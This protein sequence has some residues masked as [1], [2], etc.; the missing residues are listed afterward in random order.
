MRNVIEM[1]GLEHLNGIAT[2]L[3]ALM[4]P[5]MTIAGLL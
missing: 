4:F 3:V 5:V 1:N 2:V